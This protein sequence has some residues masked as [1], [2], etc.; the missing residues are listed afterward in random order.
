M[1]A[2]SSNDGAVVDEGKGKIAL[3]L[4][5]QNYKVFP[6]ERFEKQ[7]SQVTKIDLTHNKID[8]LDFITSFPK[9]E[10]LVMDGNLVTHKSSVPLHQKLRTLS[11]NSN[12]IGSRD[13]ESN[14]SSGGSM[15]VDRLAKALPKLS[16]LS[17]HHNPG[18]PSYFNKAELTET[19]LFR[20]YCIRKLRALEFLDAAPV[21]DEEREEAE[22]EFPSRKKLAHGSSTVSMRSVKSTRAVASSSNSAD[23]F[24]ASTPVKKE[25]Y[26]PRKKQEVISIPCPN[27]K[28]SLVLPKTFIGTDQS[29]PSCRR[30]FIVQEPDPSQVSVPVIATPPP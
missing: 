15:F 29:C 21:T 11:L 12:Q 17:L 1:G 2:S 4:G 20:K 19:E 3:K 5:H 16:F 22:E 25:F 27:C 8:S 9:L 14:T 30:V 28:S 10:T 6:A 13:T 7:A 23:G 18:C 26:D 24:A